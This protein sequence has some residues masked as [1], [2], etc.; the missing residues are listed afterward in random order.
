M[1]KR[2]FVAMSGGVDSSVAALILSKGGYEVIGINLRLSS[3]EKSC[4]G[5]END[6]R[7]VAS[8]LG[9]P[10][11]V[12]NYENEFKDKV[13]KYFF[14]EYINGKTPNPCIICNEK[15]KFGSL[16]NKVKALKGDYV[17]TG[18][19][20][21]IAYNTSHKRWLLKK[22]KDPQNDQS[23][24]LFSLSQEQLSHILFPLGCFTKDKTRQLAKEFGLKVYNKP[25]S[26]DLCFIAD[27]DYKKFIRTHIKDND[28]KPGPIVDR[29]GK[30]LGTHNGIPF[31][32]I[33][34]RRGIGAHLKPY[35]VI[36]INKGTNT[37]TI[38]EE[39]ELYK[40]TLVADNINSIAQNG[41]EKPLK[42]KI[43]Y[44]HPGDEAIIYSLSD[45]KAEIRFT[46]PQRAITPGQAIVFYDN[47]IV[48]GGGW[49][50]H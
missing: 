42:A 25:K 7:Y 36:N 49:I 9:I 39:Q 50:H 15:I 22:G 43:R 11:Y 2:V 12:I 4:C 33:G 17:A 24:F 26:C 44:K 41:Y 14:L 30:I 48:I 32:T 31:Y 5:M 3:L 40:D 45:N 37:I 19:Y 6:A 16:L 13:I 23:Y 47:D 18:H 28:F 20:A 38:G 21:R 29:N 46:K 1:K 27:N 8:K 34:Q 35:Y 10:F